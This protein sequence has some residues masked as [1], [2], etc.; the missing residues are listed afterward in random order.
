MRC[1]VATNYEGVELTLSF[2]RHMDNWNK[3]EP[4]KARFHVAHT[5]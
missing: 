5:P 1:F 4:L 2:L 3:K